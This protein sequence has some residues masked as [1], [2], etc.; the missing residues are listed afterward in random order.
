MSRLLILFAASLLF[1]GGLKAQNQGFDSFIAAG[2]TAIAK[3]NYYNGYKYYAI[4]SED[5]WSESKSYEERLS[6]VLYK[7]GLSA[8]NATAY[9]PAEQY[10]LKLLARPDGAEYELAKF[11]LAQSTFRQGRYDQAVVHYKD[12]LANSANAPLIFRKRAETQISD[13]DQAIIRM[14]RGSEAEMTH[15]PNGINTE[16][17]DFMYVHGP[18]GTR[19]FSSNNFK[20]KGDKLISKRMLSRIMKQTG[21]TTAEALPKTI[22]IPNKNI[23]HTSFNTDM[24][25]VYYSVCEWV[26][27]DEL[28]CDLY[29]A[30]VDSDGNWTNPVKLP[31]N[32][33]GFST[34][35]PSFGNL[36]ADAKE[37][38]YFSSNRPGTIGEFDLYRAEVLANNTF[39]EVE[40]LSDLN[41]VGNDVSPFWYERLQTLYFATDGRFSFGG[42]DV[43]K[44]F[45][46]KGDF[47]EPVNVGLPVNSSADDA[48]YTRFDDPGR[49]YVASRNATSEA[50]YYTEERDV[51]CYDIYEFEPDSRVALRA[52]TINGLT[53]EDLIGATVKLCKITPDGPV[54][55]D[56]ITNLDGNNFDFQVEPGEQYQLKAT[57][58]GF[59]SV[60]DEFDLSEE[61]YVDV[62]YV[63]RVLPMVPAVKL[64]VYTFNNVDGQS[65]PGA[66]VT[67]YEYTDSGELVKVEEKINPLAND[68]HFELEIGK[69]YMVEGKKRGFGEDYEIVDLRDYDPND[70]SDT[71]RVDL[72]LGQLLDVY[73]IDAK[74]ELPLSAAT[75][76]LTIMDLSKTE[77]STN[78][79]GNDFHYVVNLDQ[80]FKIEVTR[81]GYFPRDVTLSF[82][83]ED[84]E[85]FDGR[86]AVTIPMVND[87]INEFLD[88]RVYFD[89]DH[90]DPDALRST[91]NKSYDETYGP[92]LE[93]RDTFVARIA[94]GLDAEEGFLLSQ[95]VSEFFDEQVIAG[96]NDLVKLADA[97]VVHMRNGQSYEINLVGFASPRAPDYYNMLLSARRNVCLMNFFE[98]FDDGTLSQYMD[99]GQLSF[100]SERRGE[101]KDLGRIYELIEEERV[102]IFSVEA[103]LER[104]VEFPKIFTNNSRK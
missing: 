21:E 55:I 6:E 52:L 36:V 66:P 71:I 13:A 83:E 61:Q 64:D 1:L 3:K 54:E 15:L 9:V 72:T 26:A 23:S 70:G 88:F 27:F 7:A 20:F 18:K 90:P 11:Y 104:R 57:L 10:L 38:L 69:K 28:R 98:R 34:T 50:L 39:G 68:T 80:E 46:V 76:S 78:T 24:S 101:E 81:D 33:E 51:C 99:D 58:D 96:Y 43:Y 53:E 2:D 103:S 73:V 102:S 97:L 40:P 63:E 42:L 48:Y 16:D 92:Y 60:V 75:V 37:Y 12:F 95:E 31:I 30:D 45:N 93:R 85:R 14:S 22:N 44:A 35:M 49:G 94:R 89:N 67:I 74:T 25:K 79:S 17:S 87:D 91:T 59:T 65:L 41:T 8:Y 56:E 32:Q 62:P 86:L 84:I 29:G 100:T 5:G 77:T 4:A 47:K 82:T 19:F